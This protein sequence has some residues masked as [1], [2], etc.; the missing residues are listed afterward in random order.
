MNKDATLAVGVY[1]LSSRQKLDLLVLIRRVLRFEPELFVPIVAALTSSAD[2]APD[3]APFPVVPPIAPILGHEHLRISAPVRLIAVVAAQERVLLRPVQEHLHAHLLRRRGPE[4]DGLL[5]RLSVVNARRLERI[6]G[7]EGKVNRD[8]LLV[9]VRE[10][11]RRRPAAVVVHHG[12]PPVHRD[13]A[14][15]VGGTHGGQHVPGAEVRVGHGGEH[16]H[17]RLEPLGAPGRAEGVVRHL[18]LARG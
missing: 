6:T 8:K 4:R 15:R 1:L 11:P 10:V 18:L 12:P 13:R 14:V 16:V 9:L 3:V 2:A 5:H 17:G 7:V